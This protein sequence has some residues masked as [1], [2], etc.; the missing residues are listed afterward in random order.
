[1]TWGDHLEQQ[2]PTDCATAVPR[3]GQ[4]RR[5]RWTMKWT[6]NTPSN[7]N[8]LFRRSIFALVFGV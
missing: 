8:P 3:P 5:G 4:K 2:T 7:E 1:M 6:N